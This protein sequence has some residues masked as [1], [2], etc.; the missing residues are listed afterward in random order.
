M[1]FGMICY[2]RCIS[3]VLLYT[4]HV[5]IRVSNT[6]L[7]VFLIMLHD[8]LLTSLQKN[9]IFLFTLSVRYSWLQDALCIYV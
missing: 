1:F 2:L 6:L 8:V 3:R 7:D 5:I 9:R 4:H